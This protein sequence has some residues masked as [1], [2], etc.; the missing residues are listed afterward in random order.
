[1]LF[2]PVFALMTG[3]A[4]FA[5]LWPLGRVRLAVPAREADLA[6]YRDQL[7]EIERDRARGVIGAPELEA[8]SIEVSR[9]LIAAGDRAADV[10][11]P[12]A[13]LR[14]RVAA[15]VALAGVPLVAFALYGAI[16]SPGMSDAPLQARLAKPP[17]QQDVAIL[18]RRIETH[19]ASNPNDAHGWEVLAPIYLRLGR[20]TDAVK[21][22]TQ[23]LQLL[24]SNAAREA[25]LGEAHVAAA[26]GIVDADARAA[27]ERALQHD[28][29]NE[30]AKFFLDFAKKR[31]SRAES[32]KTQP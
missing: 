16:G 18:V 23:V 6:V 12:G 9:R 28:P 24:G 8:A 19:L 11:A 13:Q 10:V 25:D 22:R 15:I 5:V 20:A 17:A 7:G 2:W 21:A 31:K 4:V 32:G 26:R 27:F 29:A 14:R 3:A 1:M 30:K